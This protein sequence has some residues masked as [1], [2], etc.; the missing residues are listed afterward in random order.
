MTPGPGPAR[1]CSIVVIGH[2]DHGKTALVRALTG[3]DTD[4]LPEERARGLSIALGFA[5]MV[6]ASMV[7]G[8]RTLDLIDAPGHEDFLLAM[9][10]GASAARAVLLV[11][12]GPDGVERQTGEHL[13]IARLFSSTR[14][15]RPLAGVVA[16]TKWDR[17]APADRPAVLSRL[18]ADLAGGP[19]AGAPLIAC[20]AFTG[21]GI[22]DLKQALETLAAA[23]PPLPDPPGAFLSVDRSFA[24]PGSGA[25]ATGTL[26]GG[27]L[28][29]GGEVDLFPSGRR[30]VIRRLEQ[31]GG[32]A[33]R[34]APGSRAAVN[35]RGV[36]LDDL[37]RGA[38][39]AAPGV[40]QSSD[41]I[42]VEIEV[43]ADAAQPMKHLDEVRMLAG[44]GRAI[45][46]VRLNQGARLEP[47]E[48]AFAQLRLASGQ[49]CF[50]GQR[51]VLRALSPAAT[52]AGATVLDPAPPLIR[53]GSAGRLAVLAAAA[54]RDRQAVVAALVDAGKGVAAH[55]DV[56]RLLGLAPHDRSWA[57]EARIVDLGASELTTMARLDAASFALAAGLAAAH[58]L[59]PRRLTTP[60]APIRAA[61][62]RVHADPLIDRALARLVQTGEAREQ[63][64]RIGLVRHI[65]EASLAPSDLALLD[66]LEA[67]WREAGVTPPDPAE[68]AAEHPSA[69]DLIG[70]LEDRGR[71][72]R[73]YNHALRRSVVFHRDAVAAALAAL[74]DAF[75]PPADFTTGA[76]R[77]ALGTSRKFI[78]PLLEHF[79]AG[80][81]T[82]RS[83][84]LRRIAPPLGSGADLI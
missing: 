76:A 45:A 39:I 32:E 22:G 77:E 11:V 23:A 9:A 64:D 47:G 40:F 37:P 21:E 18:A 62:R 67:R 41:R 63:G 68:A 81:R 10:A 59:S 42:D 1:P 50:A 80:G 73:L 31:H 34:I 79:D 69:G 33:R 4:R 46:T 52:I 36:A 27:D 83:G 84:D 55:A 19:L 5:P 29:Q 7:G 71:L 51:I 8:P 13:R 48:R 60:A 35:L 24:A 12:S 61:L 30:A 25:V 15:A 17:V 74:G 20:S 57:D 3:V 72:V 66:E 44:A 53:R 16:V 2:V 26:L 14:A 70:L 28:E 56:A 65:P 6:G 58:A 38:L 78:V 82:L 49:V 54:V 75:P 43:E